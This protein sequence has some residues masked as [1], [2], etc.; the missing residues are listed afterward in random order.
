MPHVYALKYPFFLNTGNDGTFTLLQ[1]S[2]PKVRSLLNSTAFDLAKDKHFQGLRDF[3]AAGFAGI[4]H[5]HL[6][7]TY[8]EQYHD[9]KASGRNGE[10]RA[11]EYIMEVVTRLWNA[12]CFP[13]LEN[14]AYVMSTEATGA[15]IKGA[16]IQ[17]L[18][19]MCTKK[20][21]SDGRVTFK[22][23]GENEVDSVAWRMILDTHHVKWLVANLD[24]NRT[25][26]QNP[27]AKKGASGAPFKKLKK[28]NGDQ[29]SATQYD[30]SRPDR[31]L[32]STES[33][34]HPDLYTFVGENE[35]EM[36]HDEYYDDGV[37]MGDS[38]DQIPTGH[39]WMES[40]AASHGAGEVAIPDRP[41]FPALAEAK[42]GC[43]LFSS[44]SERFHDVNPSFPY[45]RMDADSAW[46]CFID[47]LHC[48][49]L[50]TGADDW[51]NG[52]GSLELV[53]DEF[54]CWLADV[55]AAE[56]V[57]VFKTPNSKAPAIRGFEVKVALP[58]PSQP[59]TPLRLLF[60]T[61][62][63]AMARQF[64]PDVP[65]DMGLR[66]GETA[67]TLALDSTKTQGSISLSDLAKFL[68]LNYIFSRPF[69]GLLGSFK[70]SVSDADEATQPGQR[71]AIWFVPQSDYRTVLRLRLVMTPE[72]RANL[73]NFFDLLGKDEFV[74][75]DAYAIARSD[76]I[77]GNTAKYMVSNTV[78]S[79][80][81]VLGVDLVTPPG[82]ETFPTL[83]FRCHA[84]FQ[85]HKVRLGLVLNSTTTDALQ[86]VLHWLERRLG[87]NAESFDFTSW[88]RE[89]TG[90]L[91]FGSIDLRQISIELVPKDE[92]S[93]SGF[94]IGSF[95]LSFQVTTKVRDQQ[96]LFLVTYTYTCDPQGTFLGNSALDAQIWLGKLSFPV[97]R[98]LRE[99]FRL[100]PADHIVHPP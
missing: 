76:S 31:L 97:L 20:E 37:V 19:V 7:T 74:I 2:N 3:L 90:F 5:F 41:R 57:M 4:F 56:G 63:T 6:Q 8:F 92:N 15:E 87:F 34:F 40:N 95:S 72:S 66:D 22:R 16:F 1:A 54:A 12:Y 65:P 67:L 29:L 52:A 94:R 85:Q 43:F 23:F 68:G 11:R 84:T 89:K 24:L 21:D 69:L 30:F 36:D 86:A 39:P 100:P 61:E 10:K 35:H 82:K 38:Q 78:G 71:S 50:C 17:F 27:E 81:M 70:L 91:S 64:R 83:K 80:T 26:Y 73:Q 47:S 98:G 48:S 55:V 51:E 99:Q 33:I 88:L 77:S 75:T 46:D 79:L 59:D 28:N 45:H 49:M 18:H 53:A 25:V 60:T 62:S 9:L 58:T 42:A 14:Q 13:S 93:Q 96:L 32:R 44:T